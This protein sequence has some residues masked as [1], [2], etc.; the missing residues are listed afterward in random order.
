VALLLGCIPMMITGNNPITAYGIIIKGSLG[1]TIYLKQTIKIAIPLL[2]CALA[3]APCFKMRFWNIGA[4]G[5]ITA[6]AIAASYFALY[7]YDKMPRPV[8]LFVM[9]VT[10][11]IAGGIWGFIPA[12]FKAKWN[13]NETL[14]TLMMNYII[15]GIVS[16]LQGGPW[17][18]RKGSQIIPMFKE[19]AR[20]PNVFGIHCGWI[21]VLVLVV[22]MHIYMNYTKHGYEIAVIGDSENTARYAGMNVGHIMMRTMFLSG[23]ICGIVGF[24]VVSGANYTLYNGVANG[25][26]FTSITVAWL[27]QL[28]AFAMIAISMILAILTKGA[29]TLQT[30]LKVPASI[31]GIVT[32]ILLFCMLSCEFF[33]NYQLIFRHKEAQK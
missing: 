4:E 14:F 3:I 20:L 22:F 6:G 21:I 17:E 25:V 9:F 23:A 15:I 18:G 31:S 2:G 7:C 19:V 12:F 8:L 1:K 29:N 33:I 13:T 27:S 11:A 32:G 28:N 10:A 5:Q 24:I 16:W 30:K 26:G